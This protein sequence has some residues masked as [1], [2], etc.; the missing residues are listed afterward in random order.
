MYT[1]QKIVVFTFGI[2]IGTTSKQR[3]LHVFSTLW[4][5]PYNKIGQQNENK[6]RKAP[7]LIKF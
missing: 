5:K 7:F 6:P 1:N 3:F 2:F 4:S